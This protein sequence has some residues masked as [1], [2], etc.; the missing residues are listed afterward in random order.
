MTP[1]KQHIKEFFEG[2]KQYTIPV[3]Q[4][5]YSWE[6]SQW[7]TFLED[8]NEATKGGNHYFFGNV[9]LEKLENS[10]T[11]DIID[12]QQRISTIIIFVRALVNV[13]ETRKKQEKF[14]KE[15]ENDEFIR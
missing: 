12:G 4:R 8:L 2:E 5:A 1:N 13:L 7:A 9:L 11:N 15:N 10:P 3:Y 14:D 6:E